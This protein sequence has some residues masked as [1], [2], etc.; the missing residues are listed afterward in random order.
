[1]DR[2]LFTKVDN[3]ISNLFAIE[4]KVLTDTISSLNTEG[5]PQHSVSANQ[6][7]FLQIMMIACNAKRVLELGTL[8]GYST[9]WIA[10]ALPD[11]GK[12]ITI[13][14]DKHYA[15]VAQ[16]NI[17]N[18]GLSQK[19]DLRIGK[20]LDILPNLITNN[21]APFDFIFI[22]ADKPPYT[23]YFEY[24]LKLSRIGTLII[25]DNVI[26]EGKVLDNNSI[27]EKVQGVQR[28]NKMLSQNKNITATII[29]IVGV[30]EYDGIAIAVVNRIDD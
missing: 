29:Q 8:G 3:Y 11:N 15:E 20:A 9:I 23:E 16:K 28:F 7:K 30:K 5:L 14:V 24:A 26:R 17:D 22:D 25:C 27:D 4:D 19:V 12:V 18:A 1:M 2:S 6:G 21:E 10:R 13:E